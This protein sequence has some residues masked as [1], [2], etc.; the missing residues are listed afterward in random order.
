MRQ[1]DGVVEAEASAAEQIRVEYDR[2]TTNEDAIRDVL[3]SMGVQP[4]GGV[5][6]AR[7]LAETP[8]TDEDAPEEDGEHDHKEHDP[9]HG[10]IFGEKTELIFA[11]L[12]GVCVAVGFGLSFVGP[13]PD[14]VSLGLYVGGYVF[15]GATP[16]GRRS[17]RSAREALR[18]TF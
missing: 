11:I 15:G 1:I 4:R 13:V 16:C 8:S 18:S 14:P 5:L 12:A 3:V 9:D 7:D 17:T 6:D 2:A 10:G